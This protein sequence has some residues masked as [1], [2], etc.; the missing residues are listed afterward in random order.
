MFGNIPEYGVIPATMTDF[1]GIV[2]Y[3]VKKKFK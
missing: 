1:C 2:E 3:I